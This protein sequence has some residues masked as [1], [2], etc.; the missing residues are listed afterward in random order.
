MPGLPAVVTITAYIPDVTL[1][2][3]PIPEACR[4]LEEAGAAVVGLNCS[5]GP[6]TMLPL[7]RDI[8]EVCQVSLLFYFNHVM[9]YINMYP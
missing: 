9:S 3:I 2:D 8:R 1:D 4:R 6:S 7:I 5:R